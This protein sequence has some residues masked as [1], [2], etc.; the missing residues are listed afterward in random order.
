[1]QVRI[2]AINQI[3]DLFVRLL[4]ARRAKYY[5]WNGYCPI[6]LITIIAFSSFAVPPKYRI[7]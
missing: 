4:V 6:F 5:Y 1:M 7:V 3:H 2:T